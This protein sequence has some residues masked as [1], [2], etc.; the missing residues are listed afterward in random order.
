VILEVKT[1]LDSLGRLVYLPA[2]V[3]IQI[4]QRVLQK[5][6]LPHYLF[7]VCWQALAVPLL[8]GLCRTEG[9]PIHLR[10]SSR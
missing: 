10:D 6:E 2:L 1:S 9:M 3:R 5:T 7:Y 4:K 8:C